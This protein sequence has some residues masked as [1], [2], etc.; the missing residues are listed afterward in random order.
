MEINIEN[1]HLNILKLSLA[2]GY[3][4]VGTIFTL[5]EQNF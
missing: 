5:G 4:G 3:S 1:F 2:H